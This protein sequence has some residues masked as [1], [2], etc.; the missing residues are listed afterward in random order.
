MCEDAREVDSNLRGIHAAHYYSGMAD[1]VVISCVFG[2]KFT[3][4]HP[5]PSPTNCHF[6]T[7][8][9]RLKE[10]VTKKGWNYIFVD[11]FL[12]ND[13]LVSSVQAKYIKF[14][15][16]IDDYPDFKNVGQIIYID[17]K[18]RILPVALTQM[19][20]MMASSA[21]KSLIINQTPA[22]K[23][24][25]YHEVRAAMPQARY[26]KNMHLT[27]QF[28]KEKLASGEYSDNV[29]VCS[30]GLLMYINK[31]NVKELIDDVYDKC[32]EHQ[33][34]ECQI[35]WC[36]LAQKYKSEIKEIRW[37]DVKG[38]VHRPPVN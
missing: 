6:F 24:N 15:K 2:T 7:N 26:K 14:L 35:Y 1:L 3:F 12:S 31:D 8:N 30:T 28:I 21:G 22:T 27:L 19:K 16:F 11:K 13:Y 32:I 36:L 18:I 33:Q 23:T 25:V 4:V 38:L 10:E 17:H 29:R 9:S 34:P 20:S 5:A 37:P